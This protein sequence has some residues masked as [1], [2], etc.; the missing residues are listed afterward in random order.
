MEP[1]DTSER[2]AAIAFIIV[3]SIL[4]V[5]I[6]VAGY[7]YYQ[8]YEKRFRIEVERQLSAIGELKAGELAHWRKDLFRDAG[9]FYNNPPFCALVRRYLETPG[10][11]EAKEQLRTWLQKVRESYQYNRIFLLDARSVERMSVPEAKVPFSAVLQRLAPEVLRSGK[12]VVADFHRDEV[13]HDIHLSVLV[14]L[15]DGQAGG[16][17]LGILVFLIDP[18]QY[19]YPLINRWPTPS[20]TAETLLVRR[21]GND[22][23]FLNELRFRKNAALNL[24]IPL[25]SKDTPAVKSALGQEGIVEGVDYR[26]VPVVADVRGIPDSPWFL[27]TRMDYEEVYGP[28]R[29]RLLMLVVLVMVLLASAA[30]GVG[31]VWRHQLVRF[32]RERYKAAQ[33]LSALSARQQAILAAVPDIIM[34]VDNNKVY[35]WAN[36]AG[37]EFFGDDVVGKEAAF[38]FEGEQ[39]TYGKVRPIFNGDEDVLYVESLQRRKDGQKRL[40]AWWCRVLKD[41]KGNVWGALSSARDITEQRQAEEASNTHGRIADIFLLV[42]D[43]EVYNEVL[44]VVLEVMESPDGIFGYIDDSGALVVPAVPQN[45]WDKN[46]VPGSALTFP[47]DSRGD[48]GWSRAIGEKRAILSNE[49]S[50]ETPVG[51][52][53]VRRHI[54]LPVLFQGQVTGLFQ[55]A[56]RKTDYT[57]ADVRR[58]EVIAAHIAPILSARLEREQKEKELQERN[59]ELERFTY[60]ISHDLKSPLVTIKT[61]LGYL[62]QDLSSSDAER[63]E[64]DMLYMGTAADKM[65]RLLDEL[66]EM[67]R[68]GR[69]VNPPVLVTLR[70]VV[71]EV[72]TLVAGP[73][74]ERGVEVRLS[75]ET[76]TLLGDRPRLVEVWQNLVENAVKFMGE[77]ESPL[78]EIGAERLD[79]SMVF[80]V[81]DNGMGIDPRYQAKVFGLFEK[82]D[83]SVEGTGLGLALVKRIV[84]LYRGT[85][86][87]ES[88]GSGQGV[89]VRFT[90]P[91]A[92]TNQREGE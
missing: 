27:V 68:V 59:A 45:L 29:E 46:Q 87:L 40:L 9:V 23:L 75:D 36:R 16:A 89:C 55:V 83:P 56:N 53:A 35:T 50:I 33:A 17:A 30:A 70:E 47:R 60:T 76:I 92:V 14:P 6:V 64:Q 63:I 67:S 71:D 90:L 22:A 11:P 80:Y 91:E 15:L 8:N 85:I 49:D 3:F 21:E 1:R 74:A 13:S 77:R 12:I 7:L 69:M 25:E 19:L 43:D 48:N 34:E 65:G 39:D 61:F 5:G 41:D 37:F 84:E 72:L 88:P 62:A 58:L 54:S 28:L 51:R 38:Y 18:G 31:L 81:R 86:W 32:Y 4:A 79:R 2:L 78:I 10:D 26:G 44:R 82:L 66:L 20:R 42:P 24:R 73:I 57:A 52:V